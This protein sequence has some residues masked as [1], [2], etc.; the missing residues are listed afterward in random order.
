MSEGRSEVAKHLLAATIGILCGLAWLPATSWGAPLFGQRRYYPVGT[1]PVGIA[2]GQFDDTAGLDLITADE[3]NTATILINRGDG[4]FTQSKKVEVADRFSVTGIAAGRFGDDAV[5]D[6]AL[7]ADDLE[8]FPDFNGAAVVYTSTAPLSFNSNPFTVGLFPTCITAADLTADGVLDLAACAT[9]TEG[10]G[11]IS[12]LPGTGGGAF[13]NAQP[14]DIGNII[15]GRLVSG[16]LDGN[17]APGADLVVLDTDGDQVW[18]LYRQAGGTPFGAPVAL[19]DVDAPTDAAIALLNADALPDLAITSRLDGSVLVFLQQAP[20]VF[21]PPVSYPVGLLPAAVAAGD[22]D[23]DGDQDLLTANSGSNNVTLLLNN[24]DGTFSM[25]E[26]VGVGTGPIGLAVA[27]FNGDKKLDFA[28]ADQEDQTFGRDTQS[29]SVVLNG[30]S[31]PFTPTAT[32]TATATPTP[33]RTPTKTRTA[34]R[35]ATPTRTPTVTLTPTRTLSPLPSATPTP[36]GPD[37]A[38]CDGKIDESDV[39]I[40]IARIFDNSPA[41][42]GCLERAVTAADLPGVVRAL[43][44]MP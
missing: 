27:D 9:S 36:A 17:G 25:G 4:V 16:D 13:S 35:T 23:G 28:T 3:G 12:L 32:P 42:P 31:P 40:I 6:F 1:S 15:P 20:G 24:G 29:V 2:S 5:D 21:A 34:T 26:T 38:N 14:I 33:T 7:S 11:Q 30:V 22:F 44:A 8:S 43:A 39:R 41:A 37:D 18:F 19:A 10:N